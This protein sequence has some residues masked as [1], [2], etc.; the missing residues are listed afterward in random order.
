MLTQTASS[1]GE[2]A[3]LLTPLPGGNAVYLPKSNSSTLTPLVCDE[4]AIAKLLGTL[5]N[6]GGIS[7]AE[8]S[9]RLGVT[10][11]AVRQYMRGRRSKPSLIWF[12][13]FA[14]ACGAK[15]VIEFPSK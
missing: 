15:L 4:Q 9:R 11:N 6:R 12:I 10:S 5:L 8:A 2:E 3:P 1:T 13:K 7:I 14:Q